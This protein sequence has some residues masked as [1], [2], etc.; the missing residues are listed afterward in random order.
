MHSQHPNRRQILRTL[1]AGAAGT[2]ASAMW[3]ESLSALS[4]EHAHTRSAIGAIAAQNWKPRVLG[5]RQNDQVTVLSELIIPATDTPGAKA[6]QVN[7]FV[8]AVL[9]RAAPE[10]RST[11]VKGLAWIDARSKA[12]FKKDLLA[13][14]PAEQI[15][16]L[17]RLSAENS[18]EEPIGV[19]FFR[20]LK[21]MTINGYYTTEIG[22]RRELGDPGQL[23]VTEFQ[24]CDHPEHQ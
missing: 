3:V 4:E 9:D 17:T 7:R 18:T 22:L 15:E 11:F 19:E 10:V 23:F 14:A 16:L 13:A 6:A 8:D 20:A 12:L 1:A 5:A 21:V 2:A 24:G